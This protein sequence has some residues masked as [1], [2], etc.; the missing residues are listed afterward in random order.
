MRGLPAIAIAIAQ[1]ATLM[2]LLWWAITQGRTESWLFGAP[3]IVAAVAASIALQGRQ[4]WRLRPL[5]AARIL[6]WFLA[7]SLLAGVD[8]ALRVLRPQPRIAPA[9]V[10]VRTRLTDPG[11]RVLLA[12]SMSLLP[13]TLS[14]GLR[15][16]A[17]ELHVLDRAAPAVREVRAIETRIAELLGL[18][19]AELPRS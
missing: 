13:G 10:V 16:D 7:R 12:D 1:R 5:A 2:A 19:L 3:V 11:A 17:L 9:F 18:R 15:G 6:P 8:V 14:A 4:R